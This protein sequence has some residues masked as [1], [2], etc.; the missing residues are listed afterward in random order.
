MTLDLSIILNN[1]P[2]QNSLVENTVAGGPSPAVGLAD[3]VGDSG[4]E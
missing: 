1:S 4:A 2:T 3:K